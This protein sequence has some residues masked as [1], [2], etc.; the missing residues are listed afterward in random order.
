LTQVV[1][2]KAAAVKLVDKEAA[3]N[4]RSTEPLRQELLSVMKLTVSGAG[5]L[6]TYKLAAVTYKRS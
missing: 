5:H 1:T 3:R 6:L 4:K 2:S